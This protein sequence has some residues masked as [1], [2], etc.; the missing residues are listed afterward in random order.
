[1]PGIGN[2]HQLDHAL[3]HV[4]RQAR[5]LVKVAPAPKVVLQHIDQAAQALDD[6]HARDQA[7]GG[8]QAQVFDGARAE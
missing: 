7:G 6:A 2:R 4:L 8:R 5:A 1:M 3:R